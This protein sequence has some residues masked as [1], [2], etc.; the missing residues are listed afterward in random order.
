MNDTEQVARD[1]L[2]KVLVKKIGIQILS[3]VIIE[4]EAYKGKNDPASHAARKKTERNKIMFGEVGRAY[5]YFTY[6]MHYCFN[7][8]AKKEEDESGAVLIRAIQPQKGIKHMIKNRKT[9][10]ISNL[11]NGPGKLTQA[12]QITLKHYNLDLTK[13]SS[14]FVIDGKKPTKIMAKPRVGIKTGIDKLWNFSY[15]N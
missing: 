9:D 11:A 3:G 14:L 13:N 12:L 7:V 15:K 2:G 8:I 1:L 5:V 10:V 6:G 4:T